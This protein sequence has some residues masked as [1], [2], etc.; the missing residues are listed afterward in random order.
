MLNRLQIT[1]KCTSIICFISFGNLACKSVHKPPSDA[2]RLEGAQTES[3]ALPAMSCSD[4]SAKFVNNAQGKKGAWGT[5]KSG[6]YVEL[7]CEILMDPNSP[8]EPNSEVDPNAVDTGSLSFALCGNKKSKVEVE[9]VKVAKVYTPGIISALHK[10][11]SGRRYKLG[12][13]VF[14]RR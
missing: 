3:D 7:K 6:D 4:G 8:V 14:N 12:C 11:G 2:A 9:L 13:T 5:D 10:V 1:F